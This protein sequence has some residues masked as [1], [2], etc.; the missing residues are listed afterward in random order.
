L[1][2][3]QEPPPLQRRAHSERGPVELEVADHVALPVAPEERVEI[4]L[5]EAVDRLDHL[6]L[7]GEAPHL[8]VRDDVH[9][10]HALSQQHLVDRRVL[11]GPQLLRVSELACGQQ[12]RRPQ[13]TPDDV[14]TRVDHAAGTACSEGRRASAFEIPIAA[15]TAPASANPAETS[16]ATRN[17]SIDAERSAWSCCPRAIGTPWSPPCAR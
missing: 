16:M 5:P 6:A 11:R 2:D 15:T 13:Q 12:L 10:G 14:R 3:G 7:E 9:P 1:V 8:A 17:A 4:P